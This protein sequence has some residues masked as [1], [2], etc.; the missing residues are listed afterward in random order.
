[1]VIPEIEQPKRLTLD[2]CFAL[3][4]HTL[5]GW[6]KVPDAKTTR[7]QQNPAIR[8]KQKLYEQALRESKK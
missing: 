5:P 8:E 4:D 1:M 2:E 6:P 7:L 3:Y